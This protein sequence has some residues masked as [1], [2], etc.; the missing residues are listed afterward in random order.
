[1]LRRES[2]KWNK[3]IDAN[4]FLQFLFYSSL[5]KDAARKK[6]KRKERTNYKEGKKTYL[7]WEEKRGRT[8]LRLYTVKKNAVTLLFIYTSSHPY[9]G[10][11]RTDRSIDLYSLRSFVYLTRES[12]IV[13]R[14]CD[15]LKIQ[16]GELKVDRVCVIYYFENSLFIEICNNNISPAKRCRR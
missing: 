3:I 5:F 13:L 14:L 11:H 10:S 9:R 8:S 2:R 7:E 4:R 12:L 15:K 1:M 16:L 6:K